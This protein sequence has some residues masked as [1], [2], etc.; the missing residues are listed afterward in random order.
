VT[1]ALGTFP[2]LADNALPVAFT[3]KM[4]AMVTFSYSYSGNSSQGTCPTVQTINV[5]FASGQSASPV[6]LEYPATVCNN[7]RVVVSAFRTPVG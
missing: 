1:P 6:T 2:S 4:G 7:G 3:A 5:Q